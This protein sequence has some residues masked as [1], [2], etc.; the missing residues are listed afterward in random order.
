MDLI[1]RIN[2]TFVSRKYCK[3]LFGG[4]LASV[5]VALLVLSDSVIAGVYIDDRAVSAVNLVIPVFSMASFFGMVFSLGVPILYTKAI[6]SFRKDEADKC[7]GLGL[8]VTSVIG[9]VMFIVLGLCTD[10][11]LDFYDASPGISDMAREY[12]YWI[13]LTVLLMPLSYYLCEMLFADGD[14]TLSTL[15]GVVEAGGNILFSVILCKRMGIAG[16]GI[17]SLIGTVLS[18]LVCFLHFTKKNNT[19][20]INIY[21]S[22]K[23]L[24]DIGKFSLIDAGAYLFISVFTFYLNKFIIVEFGTQMLVMA[25]VITIIKELELVFD[26]IG[27]AATPI[28]S[29]YLSEKCYKGVRRIWKLGYI[30]AIIEGIVVALILI[31][32]AP[33]TP[34]LFGITDSGLAHTAVEGLRIMSVSLPFISLLYFLTSYHLIIERIRL[35]FV[36]SALRDVLIAIPMTLIGGLVF[37]IY[38]V[39]FGMVVS[40]AAAWLV[41]RIWVTVKEGKENWPLLINGLEEKVSNYIFEFKAVPEEIIGVRDNVE[42][43]LTKEGFVSRD[44]MR[45][46]FIVEE[47]FMLI[48]DSNPGMEV[49]AECVVVIEGDKVCIIA[50][51]DGKPVDLTDSDMKIDSFRAYS[52]AQFVRNRKIKTKHLL[53]ISFNRNIFEISMHKNT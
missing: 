49:C 52:M 36:V 50:R 9:L 43:L 11:Y 19:L 24:I 15:A 51:D 38:G 29:V 27:E 17:G 25:S 46:L 41:T 21:F 28:I 6:G 39:F 42:K 45:C 1:N 33:L 32:I 30:T 13:R 47:T 2:R 34:S 10:V 5:L 48:H 7:F 26:G 16:L 22:W 20:R 40:P 37:G 12:F 8:T 4:T 53:A 18:L 31:I 23:L 14:E 35:G 3:M 44:I